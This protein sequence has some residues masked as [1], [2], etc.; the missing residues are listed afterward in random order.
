MGVV[1][2]VLLDYKLAN[3]AFGGVTKLLDLTPE[4]PE[5]LRNKCAKVVLRAQ[6]FV[7]VEGSWET[8]G[9]SSLVQY[10]TRFVQIFHIFFF[11]KHIFF[12]PPLAPRSLP[13]RSLSQLFMKTFCFV[14]MRAALFLSQTISAIKCC[15]RRE[16]I[17]LHL[18]LQLFPEESGADGHN[19]VVLSVTVSDPHHI[20]HLP[21]PPSK[22][23][24]LPREVTFVWFN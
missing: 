4:C 2:F 16:L 12:D 6:W 10:K 21:S 13:S 18:R 19:S 24:T 22:Y 14:T 9:D 17:S 8:V 20:L 11:M 1:K 3:V 5:M 23:Q 15:S 7:T